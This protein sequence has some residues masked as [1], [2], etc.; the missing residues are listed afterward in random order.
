MW[1]TRNNI[2]L[3]VGDRTRRQV[4]GR[5]ELQ[6]ERGLLRKE[7]FSRGRGW[8]NRPNWGSVGLSEELAHIANVVSV[9]HRENQN[10]RT[11]GDRGA[12]VLCEQIRVHLGRCDRVLF[13]GAHSTLLC[14]HRPGYH[15]PGCVAAFHQ[16]WA[17]PTCSQ[18][19]SRR[20]PHHRG[21]RAAAVFWT[22]DTS[23][24]PAGHAPCITP[25]G[26]GR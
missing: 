3:E 22:I 17:P 12:A 10:P 11:R 18:H 26:G 8:K 25:A 16:M 19:P 13:R 20:C 14:L 23:C 2:T 1:E 9:A 4:C 24:L 6:E 15:D 21:G 5:G 7:S